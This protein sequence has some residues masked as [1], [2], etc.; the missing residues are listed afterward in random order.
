[1]AVAS[2]RGVLNGAISFGI[3]VPAVRNDIGV[4]VYNA[5]DIPLMK[6]N[7]GMYVIMD[8]EMYPKETLR[9]NFK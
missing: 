1:M 7:D 3:D 9:G 4:L 6:E 5:L 8:G 2:R